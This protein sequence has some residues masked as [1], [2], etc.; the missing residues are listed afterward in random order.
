MVLDEAPRSVIFNTMLSENIPA[1]YME[2]GL[3]AEEESNIKAEEYARTVDTPVDPSGEN[4]IVVDNID[5]GFSTYDPSL[6]NPLRKFV[7]S[8][9]NKD[10]DTRF[11]A[12]GFGPPPT[13]WS[14]IA[15]SDYYGLIEHSAMVIRGGNGTKTATWQTLLPDEAY[16]ELYVYLNEERRFGPRRRGDSPNGQ[17]T[18]RVH[19]ADGVEE[20]TI[21]VEDFEDGW[22]SLGSFYITSADTAK[23]VLTN[24]GG[25]DKV[26]ADAVK[27]VKEK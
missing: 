17:Y 7:E 22:N 23:V 13:T 3:R 19:H 4:G 12:E 8:R 15:N 11:T 27:W 25:A 9:K 5:D 20:I 6:D 21:Q 16:Y 24:A 14:L 10:N 1:S 2:F 26:V 18:Y